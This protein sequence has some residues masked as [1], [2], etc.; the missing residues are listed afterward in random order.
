MKRNSIWVLVMIILIVGC[1]KDPEFTQLSGIDANVTVLGNTSASFNINTSNSYRNWGIRYGTND[2][3][4]DEL[5]YDYYSTIIDITTLKRNT[6]YYY[7]PFIENQYGDRFYGTT[8]SFITKNIQL[9]VITGDSFNNGYYYDS[10]YSGYR[11]H[12]TLSASIA[13]IENVSEFGIMVSGSSSFL[14]YNTG[15]FNLSGINEGVFYE[16]NWITTTSGT[17]YYKAYVILNTGSFVYGDM[18][19]ISVY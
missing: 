14:S 3:M 2:F 11:Y 1:E 18:R 8:G 10:Y 16:M 19:S 4:E 5:L 9:S 6:E 12:F 15:T 17:I 13:G 7:Q